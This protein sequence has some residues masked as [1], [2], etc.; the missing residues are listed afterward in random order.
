MPLIEVEAKTSGKRDSIESPVKN[1]VIMSIV[2]DIAYTNGASLIS[3]GNC[4]EDNINEARVTEDWSDSLE[5]LKIL[6]EMIEKAIPNMKVELDLLINNTASLLIVLKNGLLND[7]HSC[8]L[9]QSD[10]SRKKCEIKY[11]AIL[12]DRQCGVC[13]KCVPEIL[14]LHYVGKQK[15]PER[16][17]EECEKK[18]INLS[19]IW[20]KDGK[21]SLLDKE[22]I[23][24]YIKSNE[25]L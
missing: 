25:N 14:L 5:P 2:A 4:V 1:F 17:V 18:L 10:S 24:Q 15:Q 7:C 20:I 12:E 21:N 11:G 8:Q 22:M 6:G 16:Y 9:I 23:N 3:M 19:K 13:F